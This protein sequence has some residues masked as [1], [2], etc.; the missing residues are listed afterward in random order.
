VTGHAQERE[1]GGGGEREGNKS[2]PVGWGQRLLPPPEAP[3]IGLV[4]GQPLLPAGS[5]HANR[6]YLAIN[7]VATVDG[8]VRRHGKASGLGSPTDQHLLRRLRAEADALLHGAGTLRAER[9]TP[10]VPDDMSRARVARG[11]PPHPIGVVV[12]ASGDLPTEHPY[13]NSASPEWPRLVY[14]ASDHTLALGR[15]GVEVQASESGALD[16]V[17]VLADLA[18]RGIRRV[19]CE[20]GPTLNA[21]LLA[22]GVVDEMFVTVTPHILGGTDPLRLVVGSDLVSCQLTLRSVYIRDSELFLRYGVAEDR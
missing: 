18:S 11:H 2:L 12:T 17:A 9:F 1:S 16:L 20:G 5:V 13:F 14:T 10:R 15:P 4:H 19:V 22:V 21:A 8:C 3:E 7:M 6:P